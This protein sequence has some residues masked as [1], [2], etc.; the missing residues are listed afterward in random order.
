[1]TEPHPASSSRVARLLIAAAALAVP[2]TVVVAAGPVSAPRAARSMP[3]AP[4]AAI[5][6][7]G[8]TAAPN[9]LVAPL[10]SS[11]TAP[12]KVQTAQ[13]V[14][15]PCS[16]VPAVGGGQWTS[17]GH[18]PFNTRTLPD[19]HTIGPQQ[20]A[21][22][23]PAWVFSLSS[24][25][26]TA[27][28]DS[29][30]VVVD[31]C[32]F[33]TASNGGVYA[34]DA[35]TGKL[36]WR[37]VFS[38]TKA[39]LGGGIVGGAA[40]G[41]GR[42]FVIVNETG[43]GISKGPYVAAL[44]MHTGNVAWTSRPINAGNGYY[45][46]ATPQLIGGVVF[47]GFS[48]PEGDSAG[49]GGFALVDAIS[50]SIVKVTDT[51]P[52]A[53]QAKGFAGGGIWSTPAWDPHTGFAYVG[54]GNPYSKQQE[55]ARTNAILKIDMRP[56]SPTY[57][58]II[59]AYKGNVDQY[60]QTLRALSQTPV[61][62]ATATAPLPYPLD[63][64]GCGQLDL[65]FGA[66]PNLFNVNGH[67]VVGDLQKS[68]VYHVADADS[69]A[70]VWNTIVGATCQACNAASTA[71]DGG[72]VFGES[73]PGGLLFGLH[74]RDGARQWETPVGDGVHYESISEAD[75]V[76]YTFDTAGFFDAFD[77]ATGLPI[78]RRQMSQD[79]SFP[80]GAFTSGGVAIAYHTV[81]VA[82]SGGAGNGL[83]AA[84]FLI[85]YRVP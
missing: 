72:T 58:E 44:D 33:L 78:M 53:D 62:A 42:V 15:A 50:G 73:T 7:S 52:L 68:G 64:P 57:G 82:A 18:D 49:Q 71:V 47:A 43:D 59:A 14:T 26:D 30:P 34:V 77:A 56:S 2:A 16:T 61:C 38:V 46:N 60:T 24:V 5:H 84:G 21:S 27:Q 79:T 8:A 25:G 45:S 20:A 48:P 67:L 1:M 12:A 65:D 4:V 35:L 17:Y 40:V 83:P 3:A 70:P 55:D 41:A 37:H 9:P 28:L 32:A 31:G 36:V 11:V 10:A 29:T 13:Q 74:R 19:E 22:L 76:V 6:A 23:H 75:G 80:T 81:F 63:D 69:M 85:G 66:A 54:A 39:G 51:V